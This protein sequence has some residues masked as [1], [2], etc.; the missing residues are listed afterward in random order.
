MSY[1]MKDFTSPQSTQ[2]M[3]LRMRHNWKGYGIYCA[4]I[5]LLEEQEDVSL[6]CKYSILGFHFNASEETI[7]SIVEDF[8]LFEFEEI[9]GKRRFFNARMREDLKKTTPVTAPLADSAPQHQE[10]SAQAMTQPVSQNQQAISEPVGQPREDVSVRNHAILLT[11]EIPAEI[12]NAE[13]TVSRDNPPQAVNPAKSQLSFDLLRNPD[14]IGEDTAWLTKVAADHRCSLDVLR[15]LFQL[16]LIHVAETKTEP[17]STL[18]DAQVHFYNWLKKSYARDRKRFLM[19]EEERE[20]QKRER[21]E[22]DANAISYEQY[23][24]NKLK[25]QTERN[26]VEKVQQ[27]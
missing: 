5:N 2:V 26:Q 1:K 25:E 17:Y 21:D 11:A 23:C 8:N 9:E 24:L 16:F 10:A 6:D 19:R 27:E 18:R 12:S 7:R 15:K 20:R 13:K 14:A 3:A 22:R 4:I